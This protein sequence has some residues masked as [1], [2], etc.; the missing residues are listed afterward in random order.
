[1]LVWKPPACFIVIAN[2]LLFLVGGG[3]FGVHV[4]EALPA[5]DSTMMT[6]L[7]MTGFG[8]VISDI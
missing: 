1:M 3:Y 7:R 2:A 5:E 8:I 6:L 4:L